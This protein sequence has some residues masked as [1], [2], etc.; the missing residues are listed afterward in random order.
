MPFFFS[1]S[2]ETVELQLGLVKRCW[3]PLRLEEVEKVARGHGSGLRMAILLIVS[4]VLALAAAIKASQII[5]G[6]IAVIVSGIGVLGV[7]FIAI[8]KFEN[9]IHNSRRLGVFERGMRFGKSVVLFDDIKAISFRAPKTFKEKHLPTFGRLAESIE[10]PGAE[11]YRE[12]IQNGRRAALTIH[13]NN[14][15]LLVWLAVMA[16]Y[17]KESLYEFFPLLDE[18]AH[19]QLRGLNLTD[20]ER[21]AIEAL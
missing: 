15:K 16:M 18:M 4:L 13:L 20:E 8:I 2:D 14:G 9:A 21:R 17:S 7:L 5:G 3:S 10:K 19:A 1:P 11:E 12:L 6:A